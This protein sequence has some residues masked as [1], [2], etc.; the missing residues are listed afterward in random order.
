[1][2]ASL[3]LVRSP[4]AR[5]RLPELETRFN[6]LSELHR[7][8]VAAAHP[9]PFFVPAV[10]QFI[11]DAGSWRMGEQ[12]GQLLVQHAPFLTRRGA[13]QALPAAQAARRARLEAQ[14][15]AAGFASVRD[16]VQATA[17]LPSQAAAERTGMSASTI[18]RWRRS[19][20]SLPPSTRD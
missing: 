20:A 3:A 18:K 9:H 12:A 16:A 15:R 6:D 19:A 10:L 11:R 8:A 4:Y 13:L 17:H 5:E 14:A 7:I 2:V 1:M